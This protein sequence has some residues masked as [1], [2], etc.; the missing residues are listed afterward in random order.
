MGGG[1]S[2]LMTPSDGEELL[3]RTAATRLGDEATV[4]HG[5]SGP[6]SLLGLLF[7]IVTNI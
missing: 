2:T 6:R 1:G 4:H 3:Q 5:P 7:T